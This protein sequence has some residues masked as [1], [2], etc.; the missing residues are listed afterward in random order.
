[1]EV[2]GTPAGLKTSK[3]PQSTK[4]KQANTTARVMQ[5][6][7][8]IATRRVSRVMTE[9]LRRLTDAHLTQADASQPRRSFMVS[10]VNYE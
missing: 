4:I 3:R 6:A 10:S 1:M 9:S 5:H 2:A 8:E 7:A